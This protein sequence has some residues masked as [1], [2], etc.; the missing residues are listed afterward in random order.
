MLS[1]FAFRRQ[2]NVFSLDIDGDDVGGGGAVRE[3]CRH[4]GGMKE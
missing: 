3:V 4:C 1:S 2:R